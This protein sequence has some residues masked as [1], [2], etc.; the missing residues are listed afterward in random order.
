MILYMNLQNHYSV[1][2]G[3]PSNASILDVLLTDGVANPLDLELT[4]N[5]DYLRLPMHFHHQ[6]FKNSLTKRLL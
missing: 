4:D 5:E 3:T 6:P 2:P 1:Q